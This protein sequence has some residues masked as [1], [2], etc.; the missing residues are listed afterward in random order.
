MAERASDP[1]TRPT[2]LRAL[3]LAS[4]AELIAAAGFLLGGF[5]PLEAVAYA[6]LVAGLVFVIAIRFQAFVN[7]VF[8]AVAAVITAIL[9]A[10]T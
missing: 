5:A 7:L 2:W 6:V 10:F 9:G 4:V 3:I 1:P 8:E